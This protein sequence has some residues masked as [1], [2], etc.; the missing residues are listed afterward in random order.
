MSAKWTDLGAH[1]RRRRPSPLI[2]VRCNPLKGQYAFDDDT[3]VYTFSAA[4]AGRRIL[5]NSLAP[6]EPGT[7][8]GRTVRA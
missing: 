6:S 5:V 4:D 7:I 3:G 1:Y 2:R 8:A